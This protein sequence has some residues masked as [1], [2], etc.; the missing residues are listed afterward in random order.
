M[1]L[2]ARSGLLYYAQSLPR[3]SIHHPRRKAGSLMDQEFQD[4]IIYA[5]GH[6]QSSLSMPGD[7]H[8]GDSMDLAHDEFEEIGLS[9]ETVDIIYAIASEVAGNFKYTGELDE[10][11]CKVRAGEV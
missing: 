6:M 5:F 3:S 10:W 9:E 8:A 4:R 2:P 11:L 7:A 1:D